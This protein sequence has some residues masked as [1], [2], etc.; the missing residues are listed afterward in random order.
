VLDSVD[1]P[2]LWGGAPAPERD[3]RVGG[4][5][6][7]GRAA[8]LDFGSRL[9]PADLRLLACDA[10]VVPIV[11]NG[12]GQPLDVGRARRTIPD[13]LRRAVA[14]RDRGC[15]RPGCG[16]PASWCEL[17]H[18]I[19]W[20]DGGETVEH[21][22]MMLCCVMLCRFHH[23]LLHRDSGWLVRIRR[24][25]GAH[26]TEMDRPDPSPPPETPTT[27]HPS[28]LTLAFKR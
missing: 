27:H 16:R 2:R 7:P 3:H 19:A 25:A 10:R 18:I 1:L 8:G 21:N 5:A 15:A 12:A 20:E 23:R 11:M 4:V 6:A 14:A 22:C 28:R 24:V 17:H 9:H 26:S 13:G